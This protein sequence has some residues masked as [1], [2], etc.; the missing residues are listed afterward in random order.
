MPRDE[1]IA[2]E[3]TT[4]ATDV[5][6]DAEVELEDGFMAGLAF[7]AHFNEW[8]R[9]EVE[10]SG[11]W[12]DAGGDAQ[13]TTDA[14]T[15][16]AVTAAYALDGDEH[17]LFLLANLWI[18]LPISEIVRPYIGGGI[19][20]GRLDVDITG[21]TAGAVTADIIDD[22]DWGFAFQLGGGVAFG[23][24]ENIAVDVGYRYKRIN[25]ADFEFD[26]DVVALEGVEIEK[27]YKSHNILLGVR[28]GF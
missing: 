27:D 12:H 28:F 17:A 11:H 24:T 14:P 10:V 26:D 5:F 9:A 19:G 16:A 15:V 22:A 25:D 21:E 7:G 8:A 13:L 1:E 20:F 2:Y 18:D 4:A 23:L 6:F 3:N